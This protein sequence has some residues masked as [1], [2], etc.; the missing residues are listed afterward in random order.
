MSKGELDQSIASASPI[1]LAS[2]F[3]NDLAIFPPFRSSASQRRYELEIG[4]GSKH[5]LVL[6]AGR[7]G[8]PQSG[9]NLSVTAETLAVSAPPLDGMGGRCETPYRSVFR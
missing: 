6:S 1:R 8:P 2:S 5:L 4:S 9:V 3:V 7:T